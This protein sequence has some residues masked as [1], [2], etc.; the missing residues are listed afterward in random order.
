MLILSFVLSLSL[1]LLSSLSLFLMPMLRNLRFQVCPC[2]QCASLINRQ[3]HPEPKR[4]SK[5]HQDHNQQHTT[6]QHMY[7]CVCS[8]YCGT[9][10]KS[11]TIQHT[12][13]NNI[14]Q[15]KKQGKDKQRSTTKNQE[16]A[17][18]EATAKARRPH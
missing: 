18:K 15:Y 10:Y 17:T 1:L 5:S 9:T 13:T 16:Q 3:S 2:H 14:E 4:Q 8:L 11:T 7:V 12:T 6:I